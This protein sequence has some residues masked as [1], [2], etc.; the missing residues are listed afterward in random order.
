MRRRPIIT[1]QP[2]GDYAPWLPPK[3]AMI[4]LRGKWV[5]QVFPPYTQLRV[6]R[7]ER[8]GQIVLVLEPILLDEPV[9]L[10]KGDDLLPPA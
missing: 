3:Q 9:T 7:E 4:R 8:R 10:P 1:V 6:T 5:A 2:M